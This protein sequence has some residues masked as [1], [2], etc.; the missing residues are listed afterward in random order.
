MRKVILL[1]VLV[2]SLGTVLISCG[3]STNTPPKAEDEKADQEEKQKVDDQE[4]VEETVNQEI[5]D[6]DNIKATLLSV[7]KI[8]D[9]ELNQEKYE[10]TFDVENKRDDTIIVTAKEV[11]SNDKMIDNRMLF[12]HQEIS[13]G[14]SADAVL[15]IENIKGELPE[16]KETL[17]MTLHIMSTD[18]YDIEEQH[19]IVIDLG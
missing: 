1:F 7:E 3:K 16:I 9:K 4:A 6:T 17:E 2:L 8:V 12:M 11:S 10:I 15:S 13:P 5:A 14:K 19:Q 18:H